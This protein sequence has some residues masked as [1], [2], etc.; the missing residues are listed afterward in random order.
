MGVEEHCELH[1]ALWNNELHKGQVGLPCGCHSSRSQ[2]DFLSSTLEPT[3]SIRHG[4]QGSE[5]YYHF[6]T[7]KLGC[8]NCSLYTLFLGVTGTHKQ[9]LKVYA[10]TMEQLATWL[11]FSELRCD[12]L[13]LLACIPYYAFGL[14][15]TTSLL[16]LSYVACLCLQC[17]LSHAL[18]LIIPQVSWDVHVVFF[19][20]ASCI[21]DRSS[22]SWTI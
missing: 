9:A 4:Q 11:G 7:W 13:S 22:P 6:W 14:I 15:S 12:V 3:N 8:K 18:G 10:L 2:Y 19:P 21:Y 20:N 1:E 17:I 5:C 16:I